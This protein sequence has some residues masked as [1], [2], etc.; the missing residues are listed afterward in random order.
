MAFA[1][2]STVKSST[3][4][5]DSWKA[6]GFINL[7]LSTVGGKEK[8][9]GALPLR[10]SRSAESELNA[11][12]NAKAE[13][14]A[15]MA[16]QL[17]VEFNDSEA[18]HAD[19]FDLGFDAPKAPAEPVENVGYINFYLPSKDGARRKLGFVTIKKSEN[20]LMLGWLKASP[21]NIKVVASRLIVKY[22]SAESTTKG[23]ALA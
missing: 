12:L 9:L 22:Q 15:K 11:W 18:S 1:I 7:Y 21:D 10:A 16:S 6:V 13:N 3:V 23:F 14:I 4:S 5:N 2:K 8:K 19:L 17:I 20:A